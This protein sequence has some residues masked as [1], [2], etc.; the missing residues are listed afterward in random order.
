[1]CFCRYFLVIIAL[2]TPFPAFGQTARE[3]EADLEA[4]FDEHCARYDVPKYLAL[5][6]ARQESGMHPWILNISGKDVRPPNGM[7]A[8]GVARAALSA[9]RSFDVGIMQVNVYWLKTYKIPLHVALEPRHNIQLGVWILA[10]EIRKHGLNWKAVANYHTP[11]HR[12]P[13]RG[14]NYAAAVLGHLKRILAERGADKGDNLP[15]L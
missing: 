9:G 15:C 1:M 2:I 13:E 11:L 6:I 8:L 3:R 14:R 5:A 4:Y 12:N 7:A 10:G